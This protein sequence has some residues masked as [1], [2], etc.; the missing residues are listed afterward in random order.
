M[1]AVEGS[2]LSYVCEDIVIQNGYSEKITVLHGRAEDVDLPPGVK[3]D[4]MISEWMGFYLL[5]ESMLASLIRARDRWLKPLG[6][7]VPSEASLYLC[8]VSMKEY[9]KDHFDYWKNVYG[10]DMSPM[11]PMARLATVTQPKITTLKPEQCLAPAEEVRHLDL[12]FVTE[13]EISSISGALE[14]KITK[15]SVLHGFGCWFDVEFEGSQCVKLDTGPESPITHWQQTVI[16]LP[17][18]LLVNKEEIINCNISLEQD[19]LNGRRYN[20]TIAILEEEEEEEEEEE[21][22]ENDNGTEEA[23]QE[24]VSSAILQAM[25][26]QQNKS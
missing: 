7:M 8:P 20:I 18:S 24:T 10:F 5:H 11:I 9:C 26:M 17:E 4:I 12:K 25:S 15:N 22:D 1:Y 21:G 2:S 16:M 23:D 6:S 14:F 13:E 3:A 19:A